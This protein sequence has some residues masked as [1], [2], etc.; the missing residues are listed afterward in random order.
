MRNNI[1]HTFNSGEHI[2]AYEHY[3]Y[4]N[5]DTHIGTEPTVTEIMGNRI[6]L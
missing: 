3:T 6:D 2:T 1:R 5:R 4:M